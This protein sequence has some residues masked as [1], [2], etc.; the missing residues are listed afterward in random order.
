MSFPAFGVDSSELSSTDDSLDGR[1]V[2]GEY[3][4]DLSEQCC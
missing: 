4:G 2:G 3:D 1:D